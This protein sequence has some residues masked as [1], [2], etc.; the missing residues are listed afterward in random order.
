MFGLEIKMALCNR[1]LDTYVHTQHRIYCIL[2]LLNAKKHQKYPI[3]I[4]IYKMNNSSYKIQSFSPPKVYISVSS[5][6]K[7]GAS[8]SEERDVAAGAVGSSG[9]AVNHCAAVEGGGSHQCPSR[10]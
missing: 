6:V 2:L 8:I 1:P 7:V 4:S 9:C 3:T 5:S 10:P